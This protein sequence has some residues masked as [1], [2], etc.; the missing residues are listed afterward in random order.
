MRLPALRP[1]RDSLRSRG[2]HPWGRRHRRFACPSPGP[3]LQTAGTGSDAERQS[4]SAMSAPQFSAL[5]LLA[6][7]KGLEFGRMLV[8]THAK[9]Y[10]PEDVPLPE[11]LNVLHF[12]VAYGLG[13]IDRRADRDHTLRPA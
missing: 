13:A 1:F 11:R 9:S 7:G 2:T 12:V 3:P 4:R 8:S 10:E 5:P 6:S